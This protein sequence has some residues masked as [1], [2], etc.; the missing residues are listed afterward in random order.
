MIKRYFILGALFLAALVQVDAQSKTVSVDDLYKDYSFRAKGLRAFESMNDGVHYTTLEKGKQI[1]QYEYATGKLVATLLDVDKIEKSPVATIEGYSLAPDESKI[2][3][4]TKSQSIYRYSFVADYYIYD[5]R[6]HEL[7]P[8]S[9]KGA[10]QVATFSPN[11]HM[12][13]FVRDNNIF[14]KKLLYNTESQV[15]TDGAINQIINGIPDWVYEEEFGFSQ[16]M[17]WSPASDE[18]AFIRFD[19]SEV[20]EYAFPLYRASYPAMDEN[21]LYPGE[22]TYKYP[23]AGEDNA[24]VSV[25]VFNVKNRTT[26]TMNTGGKGDYYLPRIRWTQQP[27]QLGIIKL[28]RHQNRMELLVANSASTVSK[29]LLT[30][31]N[32]SYVDEDVLDNIVFLPDGKNFIYV[33]EEDGYNHIHLYAMNGIKVRQLTAGQW[34][35]TGFLGYDA[36]GKQIYFS[37]AKDSPMRRHIYAV[38]LDGKKSVQL[39]SGEG[40]HAAYFSKGYKYFIDDFSNV[41]TPPVY[42]VMDNRG[43]QIRV[44]EDNKA[45]K[46]RLSEYRLSPKTFF[47]FTTAT[48]VSLNGWMVKPLDFDPQKKYP[49]LMVQY[50][51]PNSQQVLDQWRMDWDQVLAAQGYVVAC[52]DPRGTGARGEAFRKCT[53][54]KLGKYESDDQ[55]EAAHYLAGLDYVD[56]A[57]IGIWGWSFGGFM[58]S[59]CMSKSDVFKVGIAVAPVTNW[60]FYDSVYTERYLRKPVEN[61]S[62]YDDNSPITHAESLKGRLFLIHGSADDNVHYQNQMEYVDKLVVSGVQFDMFTYPNR[63]HSIYGGPVRHHLYSMMVDYLKKNL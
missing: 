43:K 22:Y 9:D 13:A 19:E 55:I 26:K 58:T 46:E 59:L 50:S 57:R 38:S 36:E 40:T 23:K 56:G 49:V 16:A 18:L 1:N 52:V 12:I 31:R 62:G 10:Q 53:Y 41:Q 7:T 29:A 44:I 14:I 45:L 11:G 17:E 34:D 32:P 8:L 24:K 20:K 15:T 37:A 2:L 63:N 28:N 21:A 3:L 39:S 61:P 60:R 51:G 54:M 6:S 35:V 27:G 25:H 47:S 48:G 33:G 42:S 4:Y 5:F 30:V